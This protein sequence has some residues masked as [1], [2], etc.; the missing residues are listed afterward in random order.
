VNGIN[1]KYLWALT[2]EAERAV[3]EMVAAGVD[4]DLAIGVLEQLWSEQ[5]IWELEF[6][7]G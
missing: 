4:R 1:D 6:D 3:K 5:E 2:P 7:E